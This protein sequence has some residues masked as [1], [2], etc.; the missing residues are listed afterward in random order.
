MYS[1]DC[2][3]YTG[4]FIDIYIFTIEEKSCLQLSILINIIRDD[5]GRGDIGMQ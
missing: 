5:E 4:Q 2:N 1:G 3:D